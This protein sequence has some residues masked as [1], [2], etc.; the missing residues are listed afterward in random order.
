MI[1]PSCKVDVVMTGAAG[2]SRGIRKISSGLRGAGFLGMASLAA[3][4]IPR[5]GWKHHLRIIERTKLVLCGHVWRAGYY[6]R[7]TGPHV[8]LMEEDFCVQGRARVGIDVLRRVAQHAHVHA[9]PRSAVRRKLVVAVI[10]ARGLNN[11]MNMAYLGTVGDEIECRTGVVGSKVVH[12]QISGAVDS[13][14]VGGRS[15]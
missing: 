6:A 5:I 12:G 14:G 8:N 9:A 4:R 15:V 10:A 11:V 13:D 1:R 7:E 2:G 3:A